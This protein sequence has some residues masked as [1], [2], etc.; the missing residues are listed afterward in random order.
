[1]KSKNTMHSSLDEI[2]E[3]LI[4]RR[5]PSQLTNIRIHIDEVKKKERKNMLLKRNTCAHTYTQS[6]CTTRLRRSLSS[7]FFFLFFFFTYTYSCA[8]LTLMQSFLS[9]AFLFRA[10]VLSASL[11][12]THTHMLDVCM[13][14]RVL[15]SFLSSPFSYSLHTTMVTLE[16]RDEI[17][18]KRRKNAHAYT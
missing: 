1:M 2:V 8:R 4:L 14:V 18:L 7:P 16:L 11:S 10:F 15:I 3:Q 17:L 13:C 9:V 12:L 5:L 6:V